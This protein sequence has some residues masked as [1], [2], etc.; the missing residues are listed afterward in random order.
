MSTRG[1]IKHTRTSR[2]IADFD[3]CET[4]A[5]WYVVGV[6]DDHSIRT[7]MLEQSGYRIEVPIPVPPG[8]ARAIKMMLT[9]PWCLTL[10]GLAK[11]MLRAGYGHLDQWAVIRD[12]GKTRELFR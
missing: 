2:P 11:R 4:L 9:P 8:G 1:T 6:T 7:V 10:R 5:D 12:Y 3:G